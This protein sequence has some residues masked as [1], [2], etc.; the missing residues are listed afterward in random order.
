LFRPNH[1]GAGKIGAV[2]LVHKFP[3]PATGRQHHPIAPH[4]NDL[5]CGSPPRDHGGDGA[6]LGANPIPLLTSMHTPVEVAGRAEQRQATS[7]AELSSRA[8]WSQH[9]FGFFDHLMVVRSCMIRYSLLS[10]IS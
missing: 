2:N 5:Q 1:I 7:P 3:A 8:S 6:V 9:R 10:K 4:G